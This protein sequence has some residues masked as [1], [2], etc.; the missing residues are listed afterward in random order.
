[1]AT[2]R[3]CTASRSSKSPNMLVRPKPPCT[4][5]SGVPSLPRLSQY[6]SMPCTAAYPVVGGSV[7][8]RR[9]LVLVRHANVDDA[10]E[11]H[12]SGGSAVAQRAGDRAPAV[13]GEHLP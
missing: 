12:L 8:W 9:P 13:S 10:I 1:M 3:R 5:T 7:I 6:R 11:Y 4:T 2:T